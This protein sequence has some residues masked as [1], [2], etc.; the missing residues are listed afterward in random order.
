[1]SL[2]K[3]VKLTSLPTD[4]LEHYI[5]NSLNFPSIIACAMV[6]LRFRGIVLRCRARLDSKLTT[7]SKEEK[8][9]LILQAIFKY[10]NLE[11]LVWFR[12]SLRYPSTLSSLLL[13]G[14]PR[15][16]TLIPEC[17]KLAV[18]GNLL[19]FSSSKMILGLLLIFFTCPF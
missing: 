4:V 18:A 8:Q 12:K 16:A 3:S 19:F 13:I 11:L 5:I 10:N 1:M 15:Y 9:C 6:N 2:L 17:L 7:I 14:K